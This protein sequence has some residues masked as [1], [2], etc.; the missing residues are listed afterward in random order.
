MAGNGVA[1]II[2]N[3]KFIIRSAYMALLA[4]GA[5]HFTKIFFAM[6]TGLMLSRFGKP[7][8]VRETSKIHTRNYFMIPYVW[9]KKFIH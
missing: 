3:P 1:S 5:F 6:M 7:Q 9:T 8:L 2:G 4:F